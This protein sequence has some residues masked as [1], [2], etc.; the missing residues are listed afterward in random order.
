M[1]G[2]GSL[3]RSRHKAGKHPTK[4]WN[5]SNTG[6]WGH[7]KGN[8]TLSPKLRHQ[9]P[10]SFWRSHALKKI[11]RQKHPHPQ[12]DTDHWISVSKDRWPPWDLGCTYCIS[13]FLKAEAGDAIPL[14]LVPKWAKGWGGKQTPTDQQKLQF[15][16][17]WSAGWKLHFLALG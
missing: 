11:E 14:L 17:W 15:P 7:T 8:K 16:Q 5:S 12:Q 4:S 13:L 10:Q 6:C 2:W 3:N 1:S 9:S